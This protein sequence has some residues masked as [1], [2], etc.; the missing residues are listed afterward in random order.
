VSYS[1]EAYARQLQQ[2]LPRGPAWEMETTDVRWKLL[3]GFAEEFVRV[4]SRGEDLIDEVDPRTALELL[5]EWETAVSLPDDIVTEIPSTV[6]ERR[7]AIITKLLARGGAS[8]A[9]FIAL[10]A[11]MGFLVT[12][13]EYSSSVFRVG[14]RVGQRLYGPAWA[15]AWQVNVSLSSPALEGWAANEIIFRVGH[16]V[17]NRLRN[18]NGP[19]LEALF[20][21]LKPA[22]TVVLFSYA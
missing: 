10:A 18:W 16:R 19:V 21:K 20:R 7:I 5:P 13:T 11:T 17:G 9:Y 22:H 6:T 4:E 1:A 14:H 15:Y 8:R 12:I 2:L 3:L